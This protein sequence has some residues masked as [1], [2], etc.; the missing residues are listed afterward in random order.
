MVTAYFRAIYLFN[1][2]LLELQLC[3][4]VGNI[5]GKSSITLQF[6]KKQF[7]EAYDPTIENSKY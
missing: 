2:I 6:V 5:L 7:V 1:L 4:N 3:V